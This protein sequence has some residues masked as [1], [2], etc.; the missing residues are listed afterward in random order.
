[1]ANK[2]RTVFANMSWLMVSQIITSVLA[3]VWTLILARYLGV[4][5][6][7]V[8]GTANSFVVLFGIL[9]DLGMATY[10]VRAIATDFDSENRYLNNAIT[11]KLFLCVFYFIV[12]LVSL[13]ILGWD[14]YLVTIC[15]FFALETAFKS[16]FLLM[17]SSF[18]AHEM[19]KYQAIANI[20]LNVL[21]FI[22]IIICTF[23]D[24]ALYG[25][26]FAFVLA[27]V[28]TLI[29]TTYILFKKFINFKFSFDFKEY[30]HLIKSGLPFALTSLFYTIYYSI[31][32]VMITQF[33]SVYSTGLYNST[34][35]LISVVTLFYTI[36]SAVIFP[37]MS[38]LFKESTD[39][40]YLSFNKSIKY[41]S[42]ITIP[43]SIATVLYAG[44]IIFLCYGNQYAEAASVLQI[45]IW[46]VCFLFVNG[47]CSLLLNSAHKEVFVTK[48]YLFA[49]IFNVVLNLILI[50]KYSVYG[51]SIATVMSEVFI[52]VLE[53][54]MISK[55]NQLPNK[56]LIYDLIK[57]ISSSIVM[58]IVLYYAH[59][60]MWFA[61]PVGIMVYFAVFILIKG[62]DSDD[63][64]I[65]RQII[66]DKLLINLR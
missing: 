54:Y 24:Y 30:K 18:Q 52:L 45:L 47:A 6:Y 15:L 41:L 3:F 31:D 38:K 27:N 33:D 40:L 64:L 13:L 62:L 14:A 5:D 21:S 56:H 20:I 53:L 48:V 60:S 19:I 22:F 39:L 55:I 23:T 57:I 28:I 9:A 63:K 36:Y 12:V 43:L 44:D 65:L 61:I 50:P 34:F 2:V 10:L 26:A 51:A 16:I 25:V 59:L 17:F 46:T 7:G 4:Y 49:A 1:M 66:G 37:V 11:L 8:F 35:K 32:M 29:Y 58:G 42:L